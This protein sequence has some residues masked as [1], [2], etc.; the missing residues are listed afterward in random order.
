MKNFHEF[1]HEYLQKPE[2]TELMR[3]LGALGES[4]TKVPSHRMS[5][6]FP[7]SISRLSCG[8]EGNHLV[9][10]DPIVQTKGR[11][12]ST[13]AT[14]SSSGYSQKSTIRELANS[15]P[16]SMLHIA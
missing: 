16:D 11:C 3:R 1:V 10:G 2:F 5:G 7:I 9:N 6:K 14:S 8:S 12:F 4:M 15:L 13:R